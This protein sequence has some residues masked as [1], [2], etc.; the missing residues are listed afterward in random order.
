MRHFGEFRTGYHKRNQQFNKNKGKE[1]L[2]EGEYLG[3]CLTKEGLKPDNT[4]TAAELNFKDSWEKV[5]YMGKVS[6]HVNNNSSFK[7]TVGRKLL[8]LLDAKE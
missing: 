1:A 4:K 6:P 5:T 7:T 3:H 2:K 8:G